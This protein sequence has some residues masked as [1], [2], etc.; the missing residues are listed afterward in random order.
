MEAGLLSFF[1]NIHHPSGQGKDLQRGG[2]SEKNLLPGWQLR[3][4]CK[5]YHFI[6]LFKIFEFVSRK[7]EKLFHTMFFRL[8]LT[9]FLLFGMVAGATAAQLQ[10]IEH[11]TVGKG[12]EEVVLTFT[13][14]AQPNVFTMAG[15]QPRVV[16]DFAGVE[17]QRTLRVP[18][19]G[20]ALVK[21]VRVGIHQQGGVKTRLVF[22]V[23]SLKGL[24]QSYSVDKGKNRLVVRFTGPEALT[25][26]K[27][28]QAQERQQVQTGPI[29]LQA[30]D[31]TK[32]R[33]PEGPTRETVIE[34]LVE[35]K[36]KVE[37]PVPAPTAI[38]KKA[39]ES[40]VAT[41]SIATT[42][43]ELAAKA[44]ALQQ[45]AR[46]LK[47]QPATTS[48]TAPATAGY[49]PERS[50]PRVSDPAG[51][52]A[53]PV[54]APPSP[55]AEAAPATMRTPTTPTGVATSSVGAPTEVPYL[56]AIQFDPDSPKGELVQFKL[57]GF[58]PPVLRSIETGTPQV[59]CEFTNLQIAPALEG[60]IKISGRHVKAIR[61]NKSLDNSKVRVFIELEPNRSYDLQQVFFKEDNFFVL[62]VNAVKA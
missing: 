1:L 47:P 3:N 50:A 24:Q 36:V 54:P 38:R 5:I 58:Y 33:G 44:P 62:I 11:R 40:V 60:P 29:R 28:R 42:T 57:N 6:F 53:A 26:A 39:T 55:R 43:A 45:P 18:T 41:P 17:P 23:N 10:K 27:N 2:H 12:T 59:I 21:D 37:R 7:M 56:S 9:F 30:S 4:C 31:A 48:T 15:S 51:P 46:E 49:P 61:L 25:A 20:A 13:A 14:V 52:A 34:R 19:P 16:F 32:K 22:D 8:I 35:S